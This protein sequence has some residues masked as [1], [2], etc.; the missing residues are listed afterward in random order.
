[1]NTSSTATPL[2]ASPD[3]PTS[4]RPVPSK[5]IHVRG[6]PPIANAHPPP[7]RPLVP[8]LVPSVR[9]PSRL[10]PSPILG[11][12]PLPPARRRGSGRSVG[13]HPSLVMRGR[14]YVTSANVS[15]VPRY[16]AFSMAFSSPYRCIA[17]AHRWC[18]H[19][20]S[21][22]CVRILGTPRGIVWQ[23]PYGGHR[24]VRSTM[25][26]RIWLRTYCTGVGAAKHTKCTSLPCHS[27]I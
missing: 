24:Q 16:R 22:R 10:R 26:I 4:P 5:G 9:P 6:H 7:G 11:R 17:A 18:T 8:S 27:F 15:R 13:V 3:A 20:P 12:P 2:R 25:H 1:M 21:S 19:C 23:R 14:I